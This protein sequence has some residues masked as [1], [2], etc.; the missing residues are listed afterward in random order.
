M[1]A[2]LLLSLSAAAQQ[3]VIDCPDTLLLHQHRL[4]DATGRTT[5]LL[6]TREGLAFYNVPQLK[7]RT[8]LTLQLSSGQTLCMVIEPGKMQ[9]VKLTRDKAQRVRAVYKGD[10]VAL[11]ELLTAQNA[12]ETA[13]NPRYGLINDKEARHHL[14]HQYMALKKMIEKQTDFLPNEPSRQQRLI[15]NQQRY[16]NAALASIIAEAYQQHKNPSRNSL[17]QTLIAQVDLNDTTLQ[18]RP[19]IDYYVRGKMQAEA[20][21][22]KPV[23]NYAVAYLQTVNSHLKNE[24]LRQVLTDSIL[25]R[26]VNE[27][28]ETQLDSFWAAAQPLVTPQ[29]LKRYQEKVTTKKLMMNGIACPDLTFSDLKGT[30]HHLKNFFGSYILLELWTTWSEQSMRE[31]PYMA[32]QVARYQ[33]Q[34]RLK[35][36]SISLDENRRAWEQQIALENPAWP[37]FYADKQQNDVISDG[38][39]VEDVPRFVL[40]QPDGTIYDA[41]MLRPSDPLFSRKLDHILSTP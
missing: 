4:M 24:K 41:N 6:L 22:D 27:S 23:S 5:K 17:Y 26:M 37:Q 19:L 12:F 18:N 7:Q 11:A 39:A 32:Q 31:R 2:L 8:P 1:A 34:P 15:S 3:L 40:I 29:L 35:C 20:G 21:K 14:E 38:L 33:N 10:N 16:L 9:Q 13:T 30:L 25:N 36:I 28:T